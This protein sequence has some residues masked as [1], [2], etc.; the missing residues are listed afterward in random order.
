MAKKNPES[1]RK[2]VAEQ[3]NGKGKRPPVRRRSRS[4]SVS[5][6]APESADKTGGGFPIVGIGASAGGLAALKAFFAHVPADSGLAYV[7]VV[8][9]S[10]EHKSHLAEL[11]QPHVQMP[12]QQVAQ[13]TKLEPDHVY[14][15]PPNA[16][17]D[18]ID[19]H[20]RLSDL[21]ARRKERAPIDHFFRT[22]AKVHDG[23]GIGVILTGTGSDGTLGLREIKEAGGTCLVQDPAEADYDGMPQSAIATGIVDLVLP[24]A[25]IPQA[26]LDIVRTR[27]RVPQVN[28]GEELEGESRRLLHKVFAQLRARTGRDFSRY[29][30][31]TIIRRIERRMQI[32]Q[33]EELEAYLEL[34]REEPDEVRTLA[35]DLLIT[36]TSFFRDTK[37][38]GKLEREV[39]FELFEH[40]QAEDEIRVWSVGCATGEEAY[41]LAMLLLEEAGRRDVAPR[42][43]VFASDLHE[44]SLKKAREGF[45]PGDIEADVSPERL[46]RFF[47]KENGG[48]RIRKE[49]REMVV[50]APHNLLGDPPFSRLDLVCCRNLLIYIQREFQRDLAELFHYALKPDGYLLLGTSETLDAGDLFRTEDKECCLYRKR[51]VPGPEPRLPVFPLTQARLPGEGERHSRTGEPIAYGALHQ[52]MV[53]LYAP[54]SALVS[55]DDKLVHLSEHA[56]RYLLSPGGEPT[57][58]LLKLVRKELQ[59]ELRTALHAARTKNA[60]VDSKPVP[61]RFNGE[62]GFVTLHVR[63]SLEPRQEGFALVIFEERSTQQSSSPPGAP[64]ARPGK[65]RRKEAPSDAIAQELQA[66]LEQTRQ[67]LQAIIEEYESG[68]EEMKASNEELQSANEELRSTMEELETSKEELQS[69]NEEL[70]TVNQENRHKVEELSQ[71]SDDLQNLLGATDIATLFLDRDLR[72]L[73]FTTKV[74]EL[75]NVRMTDRGRPLS[76]LTHRLG[77]NQLHEDAA[78]VLD[79]LVPIDREVEDESG[80]WYLTRVMAYRTTEH[81]IEGVVITFVDITNRKRVEQEI[82]RAREY[83]ENIVETLHEP[84][85]VLNPDLTVKSGN[86]AFYD[87]FQVRPRHTEGRRIYDLGNGQWDIPALRELLEDVLPTDKVFNDYEVTH[88]FEDL[89]ER[90]MLLNGRRLDSVEL[91]LLGIRDIT[92]RKRAEQELRASEERLQKLLNVP[93][94]GVLTFDLDGTLVDANESMLEMIGY[95]R[96]DV[97]SRQLSWRKM[98]PPEWVEASE[99]QLQRMDQTGHIGPYEKEYFRKDGSRSWMLF[100]GARI[101]GVIVEYCVDVGDRKHAEMQVRQHEQRFRT[102]VEQIRDYAIFMIDPDSRCTS[103]NAGVERVLGFQEDEFLGQDVS[104]SIFT[105]EDLAQ[106]VPQQE[107]Q[108]AAEAGSAFNDRWMRRKS[109]SHFF[110]NGTTTAL[111]D[112]E[113]RLLGFMKVMRDQTEQKHLEEELRQ[114]A[115][116]LAEGARRKDEFLALLAHELRNPLAPICTGLQLMKMAKD[117]SAAFTEVGPTMQRQTEHMVTLI[118]DLLDVSRI[119]RGKLQLRQFPVTLANIVELAVETSQPLIADADHELTVRLPDEPI[120]LYADPHRLAQVLSNL[121]NNAAKYTPD[122]GHIE[123]TAQ[124]QDEELLICVKDDGIGIPDDRLES[125]FELFSQVGTD[126]RQTS[127]GL[128]IGLTLVKALVELHEGRIE[129]SSDGPGN[130]SEFRIW[131][132]VLADP[133]E[134]RPSEPAPTIH[135][136]LSPLRVLIV[137]DKHDVAH[138]LSRLIELAGHEVRTA[139]D[140]QQAVEV[141]EQFRPDV[142]L[143]DLGMPRMDGFEAARRIREQEWGRTIRLVALSGWGKEDDKRKSRQAGFD[144]HLVKPPDMADLQRVL[145]G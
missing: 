38:F 99:Q 84:L 7:V 35:D 124:S 63:P 73:R 135:A 10:P 14:V 113:G 24:L 19:T 142:I 118:D 61:V 77:Y 33:I 5:D 34:L 9:L 117:K 68:Q 75:F 129:A 140:G 32:H 89:G 52:R 48:Y 136:R 47:I 17:L 49:L 105:P 58:N 72:I 100:A 141:A 74:G 101:D 40:K 28:D 11:L 53:E 120:S 144:A 78:R 41:S 128:G 98:T 115:T 103:W 122:G 67:R 87:H 71:L 27:P 69:M 137:D 108:Q 76:D 6:P 20:L 15:I 50:F 123:L 93:G 109:G 4:S 25:Q 26:I 44:Q 18:A 2:E 57:V 133:P 97:Q 145:E 102:L 107:L 104:S 45:F 43:Q 132:P 51:N 111:R 126:G 119:T 81:R 42:I 90:V 56:G 86:Q 13:T 138:M 3:T 65:A 80:R 39:I 106:G 134:E 127:S 29:K 21:E 79:K 36:V 95:T 96:Q 83:S 54:P 94:V 92:D 116:E 131:L 64:A 70:Q 60:P 82:A 22:L 121:L 112:P 23:E 88:Q 59:I 8:H 110:A 114:L 130:G 62:S 1:P 30:R 125:V 85:L 12:V 16:N 143:M 46:Q 91:I 37:I 55:P 31:S 66:E 139:A